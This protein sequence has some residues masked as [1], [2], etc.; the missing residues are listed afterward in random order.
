MQ[1]CLSYQ[2]LFPVI[3]LFMLTALTVLVCFLASWKKICVCPEILF[4]QFEW[5]STK[6]VPLMCMCL[7]LCIIEFP[8][9]LILFLPCYNTA[10]TLKHSLKQNKQNFQKYIEHLHKN[11]HTDWNTH[12]SISIYFSGNHN[13]KKNAQ[14]WHKYLHGCSWIKQEISNAFIFAQS[15]TQL[16]NHTLQCGHPASWSSANSIH[17][18]NTISKIKVIVYSGSWFT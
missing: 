4:L 3:S 12:W 15:K 9:P 6:W 18:S 7:S 16:A 8:S 5:D 13:I 14:N 2:A 11:W 10:A 17:T 1:K